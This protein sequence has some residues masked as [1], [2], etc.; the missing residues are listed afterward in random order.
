MKKKYR[1]LKIKL[2]SMFVILYLLACSVLLYQ[3]ADRVRTD[4]IREIYE[5][6]N[7]LID[8]RLYDAMEKEDF[9]Q[10]VYEAYYSAERFPDVGFYSMLKDREDNIYAEDQN[11]LIINKPYGLDDDIKYDRR[12]LILGDDFVSDDESA[13]ISF[14]TQ[15][16]SKLEIIGKCDNTYIYADEI[17]WTNMEEDIT[18]S[19]IPEKKEI[20][21]QGKLVEFEEWSGNRFYGD[22]PIEN[23]YMLSVNSVFFP[24]CDWKEAKELNEEAKEICNQIYNDFVNDIYTRDSCEEKGLFTC[25][26][27]KTGYLDK[28]YVMP[29]VYVFHPISIAFSQ[30]SGIFFYATIIVLII[31]IIIHC[32]INKMYKQH[33]AYENN[34]RSLT[35]GI[36]HELKTPLAI[37]KGYVENWEYVDE[38]ERHKTAGIMIEE[39]D[40]MNKMVTDLLELS[41]LEANAKKMNPESVDIYQLTQSVLKRM[42]SLIQDRKLEVIL[43]AGREN[44]NEQNISEQNSNEKEYLVEADLEM[45]RIVFVNFISNVIKYADKKINICI[46]EKGKKVRFEIAN[47]GKEIGLDSI[48][49]IWNEFYREENAENSRTEGTGLGLAITKNILELHNVKY[50]YKRYGG[51]NIFWFEMKKGTLLL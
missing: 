11:F 33:E 32:I 6:N 44:A 25:Y 29:Y 12:I 21:N 5:D 26:I 34:R 14:A 3:E 43:K 46:Y 22:A 40:H 35:R 2:I 47:D 39:I 1:R 20:E 16:F 28:K 17:K 9:I 30:L 24:Y 37:T 48:K 27:A 18:Y 23:G 38:N 42:D 13:Q 36:A 4:Y 51:E 7:L 19:Y 41:H 10:R 8:L 31:L 49:N 50:G 45:M 15:G